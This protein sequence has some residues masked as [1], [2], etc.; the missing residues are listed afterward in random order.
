MIA[1]YFNYSDS[2]KEILLRKIDVD[3]CKITE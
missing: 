2:C 1:R 3:K